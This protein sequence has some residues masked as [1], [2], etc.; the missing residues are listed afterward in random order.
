MSHETILYLLGLVVVIAPLSIMSILGG[1]SL[2]FNPLTERTISRVVQTGIVA[3][4]LSR[5][6]Y[7]VVD[8]GYRQTLYPI[9]LGNWVHVEP[10]AHTADHVSLHESHYHFTIKF[11]FDRL[12]VPFVILTFLLCGKIGAF[13]N[14]YMHR[15]PGF[16]RFFLL[17]SVFV[18]GMIITSIAGTIETLFAGWEL[19]GL[20][21]ALLV[22]F[23][24]GTLT[25]C[26]MDS[27]SG[28]CIASMMRASHLTL[29]A[30]QQLAAQPASFNQIWGTTRGPLA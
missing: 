17:Y 16:S 30:Y 14:R 11:V 2:I 18:A 21:S 26:E 10:A 7:V 25:L 29:P 6:C 1:F 3:G 15:E 28:L 5:T 12:S 4:L 23:Y 27:A 9:D 20:S 8:A 19:V 13:A 24:H 22:A